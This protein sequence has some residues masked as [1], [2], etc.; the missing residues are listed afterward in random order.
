MK[1]NKNLYWNRFFFR[2]TIIISIIA[3]IFGI[4]QQAIY[5]IPYYNMLLYITIGVI[6]QRCLFSGL[7]FSGIVWIIYLFFRW[8]AYYPIRWIYRG[9]QKDEYHTNEEDNNE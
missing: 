7:I 8:I 3:F 5:I 1:I 4:V 9:L 6:I 2:L